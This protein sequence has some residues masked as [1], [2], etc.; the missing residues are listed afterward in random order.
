M[1]NWGAGVVIRVLVR[2]RVLERVDG[3]F[4]DTDVFP[5]ADLDALVCE[6]AGE[7]C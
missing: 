2:E 4:S 1:R 7:G 5:D 6:R 3:S